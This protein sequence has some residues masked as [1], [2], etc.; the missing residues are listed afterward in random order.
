MCEQLRS[1]ECNGCSRRVVHV[2]PL[3]SVPLRH[4]VAFV[5]ACTIRTVGLSVTIYTKREEMQVSR[6]ASSSSEGSCSSVGL[7][8]SPITESEATTPEAVE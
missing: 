7:S 3:L 8:T 1:C 4:F 6:F 5:M 2:K